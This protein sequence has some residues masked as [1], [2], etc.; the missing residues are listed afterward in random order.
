M[1]SDAHGKIC[2]NVAYGNVSA[3]CRSDSRNISV[4]Y[5]KKHVDVSLKDMV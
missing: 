4:N 3:K 5:N 2:S 1:H